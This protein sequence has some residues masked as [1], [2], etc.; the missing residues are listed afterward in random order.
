MVEIQNCSSSFFLSFFIPSSFFSN[1]PSTL[2]QETP[3]H[4]AFS[5]VIVLNSL[6][7]LTGLSA[8]RVCVLWNSR[9]H[10]HDN[11]SYEYGDFMYQKYVSVICVWGET[12]RAFN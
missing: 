2:M 12:F 1:Q 3:I 11:A 10:L 9:W 6:S 7:S 5:D 8:Y 4:V